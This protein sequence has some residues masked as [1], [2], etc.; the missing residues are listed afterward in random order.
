M[1]PKKHKET[2]GLSYTE[3]TSCRR[4]HL[5]RLLILLV[6]L[7]L[8]G[9]DISRLNGQARALKTKTCSSF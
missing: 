1:G 2:P 4:L 6:Q 5:N 9:D 7:G 3:I 8:L